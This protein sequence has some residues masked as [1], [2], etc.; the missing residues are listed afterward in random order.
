MKEDEL[1]LKL[2]IVETQPEGLKVSSIKH[3]K[4]ISDEM[5]ML[6]SLA[7]QVEQRWLGILGS[8]QGRQ[9]VGGM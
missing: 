7:N 6:F 4:P 5:K 1:K 3:I 8:L 2:R 9:S